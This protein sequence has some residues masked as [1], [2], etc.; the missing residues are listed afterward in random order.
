MSLSMVGRYQIQ[1]ELGRGAM[2]IVYRGFD[3][4]IGRA[5]AIKTILLDTGNPEAV[6]RL[7]RE[8][9]AAGILSHPNIV[10]VYDAGEDNGLFYIAMEL[11]EGETLQQVMASGPIPVEQAIPTMEQ[12]GAALDYAHTRKIVH[13]DVKPANIMVS[14]G[15]VKVMDFG[16]AKIAG[17]GM[18]STGEILGTPVYM[19]P[20]LVKGMTVDGR[21]D[22]FSLGAMLY[23]MVTGAKPF[24]GDT[25]PTILYKILQEDPPAPSTV[26]RSLPPGLDDVVRKAL[27]KEPS[28]RYP[29]CAQFLADLKNYPA[30]SEAVP[31]SGPSLEAMVVDRKQLAREQATQRETGL[32]QW[33][34]ERK[35][36]LAVAAGVLLALAG[37]IWQVNRPPM[38]NPETP[39]ERTVAPS[40]APAPKPP[41]TPPARQAVPPP[42]SPPARSQTPP[43][44]P[45]PRAQPAPT[46][47]TRPW[48]TV[49]GEAGR[50]AVHTEPQGARIFINGEETPYRSPVNFA[51]V[52]GR[53]QITVERSG[54]AS[55]TRE[56]V[57]RKD[58]MAPVQLELKRKQD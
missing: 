11:V 26:N 34:R 10:T 40:P 53:Y 42:A 43:P 30:V 3:P 35:S 17:V 7:Q 21:S 50:V 49:P 14:E 33:A 56:V 18:T 57:V 9:R 6:Q 32:L 44:A 37:V 47:P 45:T 29:N 31:L 4:N 54:Y 22:I 8:A 24:W 23:E 58:Q 52:P 38:P 15:R 27:A 55:E 46:T 51:V 20:E 19:S 48:V 39:P 1:A 2:G 13:R 41:T 16:I 28:A 12:I 36:L 5:V 25:L